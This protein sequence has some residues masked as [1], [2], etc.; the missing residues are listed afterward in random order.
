MEVQEVEEAA[1]SLHAVPIIASKS[2]RALLDTGCLVGDCIS[3]SIV[4][5]LSASHLLF[6]VSTTICSGF[7]NQCQNNFQALKI[8][9]SFLNEITSSLEH[10]ITTVIVLKDSPIDLIIGRKNKN[11]NKNKVL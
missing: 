3:K 8:N 7:N 5:S 4:D 9:L 6:N 2:I 10:I 1:E 11:K